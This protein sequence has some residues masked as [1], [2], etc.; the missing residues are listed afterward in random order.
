MT[1]PLVLSSEISAPGRTSYVLSKACSSVAAWAVPAIR[2]SAVVARVVIRMNASE[3]FSSLRAERREVY[4]PRVVGSNRRTVVV[5]SVFLAVIAAVVWRSGG[6]TPTPDNVPSTEY[7]A[8]RAARALRDVLGGNVPHPLGS[9]A[10]EAVR[11]R[12][13]T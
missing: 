12:L 5:L 13:A 6:P 4:N 2:S 8:A 1:A 9:V 10:H 11:E 7:A 3:G